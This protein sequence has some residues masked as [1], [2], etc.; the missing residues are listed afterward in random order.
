MYIPV[1]FPLVERVR[2]Y[3]LG[4][5]FSPMAYVH[6]GLHLAQRIRFKAHT[7]E[8]K[9]QSPDRSWPIPVGSATQSVVKS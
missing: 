3:S 1:Y 6:V 5:P 8:S 7:H 2:K 4:L 9:V